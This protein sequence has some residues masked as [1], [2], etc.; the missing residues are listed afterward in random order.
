SNTFHGAAFDY[1]RN[2]DYNAANRFAPG[3]SLLGKRTHAGATLGG[4]VRHDRLFFFAN[5][6]SLTDHFQ[7]V[8]RIT[9]QTIAD[10][11]G[12]QVASSNCTA[13]AA[14]CAAAIKFIQ[15]QMNVATPFSEH[16][17][18]GL[19]RI[20]YR[21]SEINTLSFAFNANNARAG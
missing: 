6:E 12:N 14:Q 8:N 16:W 20:D 21:R 19:A 5:L 13:T 3:Q 1:L 11:T 4:P 7:S 9:S 2:S 10:A 18:G 15:S 17:T